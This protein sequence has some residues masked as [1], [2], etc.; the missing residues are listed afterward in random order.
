MRIGRRSILANCIPVILIPSFGL[1]KLG[2]PENED[3]SHSDLFAQALSREH[4]T[5]RREAP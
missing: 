3:S 2:S 1:P 4:S 5:T